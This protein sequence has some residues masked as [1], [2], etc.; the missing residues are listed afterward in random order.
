M[1]TVSDPKIIYKSDIPEE[2]LNSLAM[3]FVEE[4]DKFLETDLGK[5]EFEK[6]MQEASLDK[7]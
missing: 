3:L 5:A 7:D 6:Y 1:Q 4:I 2:A